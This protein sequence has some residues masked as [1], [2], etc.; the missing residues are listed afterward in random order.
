MYRITEVRSVTKLRLNGERLQALKAL[1]EGDDDPFLDH[2]IDH[3][4]E[5]LPIMIE[6]LHRAVSENKVEQ[7]HHI[8]H[9]MKGRALNLG[10]E[11]FAGLCQD[12]EDLANSNAAMTPI[13]PL[14]DRLSPEYEWLRTQLK[15]DWRRP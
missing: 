4:L 11:G 9:K 2:L 15:K 10:C 3:L 14:I 1:E 8:A 5:S 12:I 6:E 13:K 7:V